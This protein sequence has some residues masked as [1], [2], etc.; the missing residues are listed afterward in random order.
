MAILEHEIRATAKSSVTGL[1]RHLFT[2]DEY[3]S[4]AEAGVFGDKRLELIEGE[5]IEMAPIGPSHAAITDP[6][7]AILRDV[8][9]PGFTVRTQ[10]P[11]SLGVDPRPS[12]PQPDVAVVTGSWRDYTGR[13]PRPQEIKLLVEVADTTLSDD[14]SVKS[15]L[16]AASGVPEYW[17]VN[18]VDGQLEVHRDPTESG[19]VSVKIYRPDET[20]EP[21]FSD[22][23]S[24]TIYDFMP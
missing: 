12:D 24:V 19:Y 16:Y 3:Y 4:M 5:I 8:F 22:G 10:V 21:L 13:N 23:K 7:A 14:R 1:H 2:R 15:T 9:G 6:L 17:I 20:V 11:V 18:L